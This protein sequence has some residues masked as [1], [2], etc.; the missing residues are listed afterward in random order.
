M[1]LIKNNTK[2]LFYSQV[3]K[4]FMA[5][6]RENKEIDRHTRYADVK[7]RL[8][9]EARYK[10]VGDSLLRE[11]YFHDYCK[12]LKDEKRRTKEKKEKKSE[13]R[14]REEKKS[15]DKDKSSK[16]KS[17]DKEKDQDS[18]PKEEDGKEDTRTDDEKEKDNEEHVS[19]LSCHH[20]SVRVPYSQLMF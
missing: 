2:F 10:A 16:D 20:S 9:S 7:K 3:R 6:L 11:D 5:L 15:K 8:D 19:L 13:K 4:D 1:R 12:I 18:D 14:D 17:R